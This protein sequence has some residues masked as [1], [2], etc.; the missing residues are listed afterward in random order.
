MSTLSRKI[1]DSQDEWKIIFGGRDG[2]SKK[3]DLYARTV[4]RP[5]IGATMSWV[6]GVQRAQ[7]C[8]PADLFALLRRH[9]PEPAF[10][11]EC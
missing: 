9:K 5:S 3:L 11:L 2:D 4:L 8:S 10:L 7:R 6:R 1:T